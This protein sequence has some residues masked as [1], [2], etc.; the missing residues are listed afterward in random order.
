MG[1]DNAIYITKVRV[2]MWLPV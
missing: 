1:V 2:R